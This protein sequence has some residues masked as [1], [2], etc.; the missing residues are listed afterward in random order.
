MDPISEFAE[1]HTMGADQVCAALEVDPAKGLNDGAVENRRAAYGDN[2]IQE[3]RRRSLL[4]LFV[5]QFTDFMIIVL[6]VAAIIAG[7]VGEVIDS[8]AIVVIVMLNGII[9]FVQDYRA[10]QAIEA[11]RRMAAPTAKVRRNGRIHTLDSSELVP[12]DVVLIETGN[13]VPADLRL[14]DTV[15]LLINEASL[16]GESISVEK[17]VNFIAE[18]QSSLGER[19]NM[20]YKLAN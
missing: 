15:Q 3:Q 6:I 12:G 11:L 16:T 19:H 1:W 5:S 8:I 9:G 7:A 14:L 18:A 20:L 17:S 4:S 10:E 13:I 2:A